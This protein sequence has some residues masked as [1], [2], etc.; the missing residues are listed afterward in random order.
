MKF[1]GN[2]EFSYKKLNENNPPYKNMDDFFEKC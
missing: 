1:V 2:E